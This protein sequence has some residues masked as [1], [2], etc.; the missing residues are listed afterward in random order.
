MIASRGE[1]LRGEVEP[2]HAA[3][4]VV[5]ID[6][7][8]ADFDFAF[9]V[10]GFDAGD[11]EPTDP[12]FFG[13]GDA[14]SGINEG[15]DPGIRGEFD[16]KANVAVGLDVGLLGSDANPTGAEVD[17]FAEFLG[18]AFAAVPAIDADPLLFD[19]MSAE[20]A[21]LMAIGFDSDFESCFGFFLILLDLALMQIQHDGLS[22]WINAG[23]GTFLVSTCTAGDFC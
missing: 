5:H 10:G 13:L 15:A 20:L 1:G 8:T 3:V 16:A 9:I 7:A 2:Q 22:C 6:E 19:V 4:H 11:A 23:F 21:A 18:S 12:I 14:G 17:N